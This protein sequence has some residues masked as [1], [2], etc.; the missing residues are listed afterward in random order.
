M[1]R[2]RDC[3]CCM[4]PSPTMSALQERQIPELGIEVD[5]V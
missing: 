3:C 1:L 5:D 2:R 4:G